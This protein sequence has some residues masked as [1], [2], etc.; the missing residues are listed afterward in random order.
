MYELSR[1]AAEL[2][3]E[4]ADTAGSTFIVASSVGPTGD[5]MAPFGPL[6]HGNAVEI[7]HKQ[8]AGLKVGGT[9]V[10]WLET[11]STPEEYKAAAE[12]FALAGI[13]WC[14]TMSFDTASRIM[15]GMTSAGMVTMVEAMP[16]PP[17]GF[18]VNCGSGAS[19]LLCAVLGFASQGCPLPIIEKGNAGIPK[20][21]DSHIHYDDTPD[22]MAHYAVMAQV[23]GATIIGGCCGTMQ[24]HLR[25][26]RATL[27][28][29]TK[30]QAPT[31][32]RITHRIGPFSSLN[33]GTSDTAAPKPRRRSG[34]ITKT[35]AE[36][37]AI[38]P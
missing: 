19:D 7:F 3:R 21:F 38:N 2:D 14:G 23:C 30:R 33:D 8:A 31:L 34:C 1:I 5:I 37:S 25:K 20:Y 15:M 27:D 26:M 16:N 10:L 6:T 24:D 29:Q 35:T 22:L 18:G 13:D 17:L 36:K 32:D 28:S 9:D 11:I 12:G 4:A